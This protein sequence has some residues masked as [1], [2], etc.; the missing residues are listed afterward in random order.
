LAPIDPWPPLCGVSRWWAGI[1]LL[2]CKQGIYSTIFTKKLHKYTVSSAVYWNLVDD[3]FATSPVPTSLLGLQSTL[4]RLV[5]KTSR[6]V[7][8]K[9]L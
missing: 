3:S 7:A 6:Q 2:F 5:W 8:P 9:P 4:S 1:P